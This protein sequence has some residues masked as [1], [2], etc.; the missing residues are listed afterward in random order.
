[1]QRLSNCLNHPWDM[2]PQPQETEKK[3]SEDLKTFEKLPAKT[4]EMLL[5]GNRAEKASGKERAALDSLIKPK[6]GPGK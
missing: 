1:M 2:K 4:K 5:L 3:L 6:A